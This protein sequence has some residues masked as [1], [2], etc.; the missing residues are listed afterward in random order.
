MG[1]SHQRGWVVLRGKNWYCYSRRTVLDL[2]NNEEKVETQT[3][4]LGQKSEMTKFQARERLE[5][6]IAKQNS[7][8]PGGRV[9]NHGAVTFGWFVRNRF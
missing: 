2:T 7:K 6:E 4:I 9:M 8:N 5:L 1:K 3:F